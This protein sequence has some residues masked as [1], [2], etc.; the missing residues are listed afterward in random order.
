MVVLDRNWF[1]YAAHK[2]HPLVPMTP[3]TTF[4]SDIFNGV[5]QLVQSGLVRFD[6]VIAALLT[7]K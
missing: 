5:L 3:I 1:I 6:D 2:F 4:T 7:A